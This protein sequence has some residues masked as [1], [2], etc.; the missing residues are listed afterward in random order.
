MKNCLNLFSS[1]P[2]PKKNHNTHVPRVRITRVWVPGY[3]ALLLTAFSCFSCTRHAVS[4]KHSHAILI[5]IM[6][7]GTI[8]ER[9]H[10][11]E[12]L[13]ALDLDR[14]IIREMFRQELTKTAAG[15]PDNIGI[16]RV[17]AQ[18]DS[19]NRQEYCEKI[20]R[21]LLVRSNTGFIH[22]I[23]ALGKLHYP[24]NEQSM[25]L[26]SRLADDKDVLLAS[27]SQVYLGVMNYPGYSSILIRN[28]T[29]TN[30]TYRIPAANL[31]FYT[32]AVEHQAES[33]LRSILK[34]QNESILLR[35][36][37][38][39]VLAKHNLLTRSE[40]LDF[41]QQNPLEG[42]PLRFALIA[43]AQVPG[44][45]NPQQLLLWLGSNDNETKAA[46]AYAAL[47]RRKL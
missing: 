3:I 22:A 5:S 30:M 45:D 18:A 32:S 4:G 14:R 24:V 37:V 33:V 29:G 17:L 13:L 1:N 28:L 39:G 35:T 10:A 34:D 19:D 36:C 31:Y 25:R 38:L 16:L 27:Y 6:Q 46:A 8:W 21:T 12:Y 40:V 42:K 7:S 43:L 9:I 11:A 23:E 15:T 41:F 20:A 47:S 2:L 44:K 26:I